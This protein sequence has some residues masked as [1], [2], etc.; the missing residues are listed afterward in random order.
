VHPLWI[1]LIALA[2]ALGSVFALQARWSRA[3]R[4]GIPAR[5]LVARNALG[6]FAAVVAGASAYAVM[7]G[8]FQD[9]SNRDSAMLSAIIGLGAFTLV[10]GR[11]RRGLDGPRAD[12]AG[13]ALSG[14][15][16]LAALAGFPVAAFF[17]IYWMFGN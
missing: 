8:L 11:A 7:G 1:F 3:R 13:A 5:S 6:W 10:A 15:L 14:A 12:F 17:G 16:Q 2:T 4:A 9:A